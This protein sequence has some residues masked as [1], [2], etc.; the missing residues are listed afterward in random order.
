MAITPTTDTDDDGS[1]T[2]GTVHT[3]AWLQA[4]YGVVDARWSRA[5]ASATGTQTSLSYSEADLVLLTN[6]SDVT[7]RSI[8]APSS[9]AKPG[10]PLI[11][12]AT[13]AGNAFF[14]HQDTTGTTA[15]NRLVN[16]AQ[17][18]GSAAALKGG[19]GALAYVYDDSA[20]RWHLV[21]HEQG[22]YIDYSSATTLTGFS[23]TT[24]KYIRYKLQG[25]T[26]FVS[27][28]IDGTS[29]ATTLSITVPYTS[30]DP[31]GA[32]TINVGIIRAYDSGGA[33]VASIANWP[34]GA[35]TVDYYKDVAG[36]AWTGSSTKGVQ[37]T[38][39]F[40]VQ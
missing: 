31:G 22:G 23:S 6:A 10:K 15:A 28:R 34:A 26:L 30:V 11:I 18:T 25:R 36:N 9:P 40:E 19:S 8:P 29:N 21:M 13:G 35:T 32:N 1:G 7:Y 3:N 2:T 12:L 16:I 27:V 5:S 4:L 24:N 37:G 20:S 33:Y 38:A 14:N 17:S 39:V